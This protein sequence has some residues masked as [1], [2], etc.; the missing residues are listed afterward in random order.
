MSALEREWLA[1]LGD[2][3]VVDLVAEAEAFPEI[4]D[5]YR[6]PGFSL[7]VQRGS[8]V[9]RD[10]RGGVMVDFSARLYQ[11][12]V[13]RCFP[14]DLLEALRDVAVE[15]LD[16]GHAGSV[17]GL[18]QQPAGANTGRR[19]YHHSMYIQMHETP[20]TCAAAVRPSRTAAP[21][22]R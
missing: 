22:R 2:R 5:A 13:R 4:P 6:P 9:R 18:G 21:A 7:S 19:G 20:R 17:N 14:L 10:S 16:T 3:D 1:R 12:P 15:I 8:T 11:D